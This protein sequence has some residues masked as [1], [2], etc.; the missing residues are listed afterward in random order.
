MSLIHSNLQE[1]SKHKPRYHGNGFIQLYLTDDKSKRLHI[2][3]PNFEPQRDHNAQIHDH[4]FYMNSQILLGRLEHTLYDMIPV[5]ADD[6]DKTHN[7][8]SIQGA[9]KFDVGVMHLDTP[10]IMVMREE[11]SFKAGTTYEQRD[12]TFHTSYK[13]C[14]DCYV[15][16]LV[17]KMEP[18]AEKPRRWARVAVAEHVDVDDVTHA[19]DP[20]LQPSQDKLWVEINE[21]LSLICNGSA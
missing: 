16:T 15:A 8:Y 20:E 21:V 6:P 5:E 14:A 9:S 7:I 2:W 3:S 13:P 19:F 18:V 1:T 11:F 10:A 12:G 17:T 4:R